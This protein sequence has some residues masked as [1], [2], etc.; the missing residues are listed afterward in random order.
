MKTRP[1]G[2][3]VVE[4][5]ITLVVLVALA[6]L[7]APSFRDFIIDSRTTGETNEF[8][9]QLNFSRAEAVK[10]NARVTMCKSSNSSSSTPTCTTAGGWEQGWISFVDVGTTGTVDGGDTILRVHPA[11]TPGDTLTLAGDTGVASY[12]SFIPDGR[13]QLWDGAAVGVFDLCVSGAVAHGRKVTVTLG[14]AEAT[15]FQC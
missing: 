9:T 15:K 12:V 4:L 14:R 5:M 10:R 11:L 3:T 7:V 2:F 1:S 8:L 6:A 13:S